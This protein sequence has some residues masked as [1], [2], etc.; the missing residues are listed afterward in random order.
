MWTLRPTRVP[1]GWAPRMAGRGRGSP[2]AKVRVWGLGLVSGVL[3][4]EGTRGLET[5]EDLCQYLVEGRWRQ[6]GWSQ[7]EA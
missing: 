1:C 2:K 3:P 4:A 5:Q 7:V 6:R